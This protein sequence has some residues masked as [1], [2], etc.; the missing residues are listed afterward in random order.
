MIQK[1]IIVYS[2]MSMYVSFTKCLLCLG[3]CAKHFKWIISFNFIN[4][5]WVR[6]YNHLHFTSEETKDNLEQTKVRKKTDQTNR[7]RF[8]NVEWHRWKTFA[9]NTYL[10]PENQINC[11]IK[12]WIESSSRWEILNVSATSGHLS[13]AKCQ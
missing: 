10:F 5:L 7:I 2:Y 3:H 11:D 6:Y 4:I 9:W 8:I 13:T 12:L 1:S